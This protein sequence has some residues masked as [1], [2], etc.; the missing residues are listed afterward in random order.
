MYVY[1]PAINTMQFLF[2][3]TIHSRGHIPN[4]NYKDFI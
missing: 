4:Y 1:N 2:T 3:A